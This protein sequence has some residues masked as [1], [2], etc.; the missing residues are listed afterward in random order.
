MRA[1]RVAAIVSLA[2]AWCAPAHA[3][4]EPTLHLVW[5]AEGGASEIW[6][7]RVERR[8]ADEGLVVATDD[9]WSRTRGGDQTEA[10]AA[11][12]RV[13]AALA[14]ARE[15]MRA[16]DEAGALSVLAGA[17]ADATRSL[18]LPGAVA[19]AAELELAMGRV[20]AQA[21]QTEL[22][23]A[24]FA[25]AFGLA[26]TRALGAAEAAPDVVALADAVMREVRAQ[27][28]SRFDVEVA[29][30]D[31]ALVFLD[32]QSLGAAPRRVET[33]AGTHVLRVEAEGAEPYVAWIDVLPGSRPPLSVTLSP[34]ALGAALQS[35]RE[36]FDD[37]AIVAIP[38]RIRAIDRALGESVV[39]WIVEGG[40]GPFDR[41]LVTA[42]DRERCHVPSRLETSSRE[43]PTAALETGALGARDRSAALAW[44]DEALPTE[45]VVPPPTDPWSEAWP[46][47]LV[48]T[49]AALVLGGIIAG[50]VVATEPPPE[51]R[52][53][54]DPMFTP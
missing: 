53:Q 33:R 27:P 48:G 5:H 4:V 30:S 38:A 24:S 16:F 3:Q 44:R 34:T 10:H 7:G 43:S 22:A 52:L 28:A 45:P 20:A 26:P 36:A 39:L 35:A 8:L 12:V 23:R 6:A 51:H 32:D 21:G 41:A 50:I 31:R 2:L 40:G 17:R 18:A 46:W 13:E 25:R 29:W 9:A 49:G 42:C 54:V 11:L 47:A 19:W 1:P 15:A 14:A 37:G